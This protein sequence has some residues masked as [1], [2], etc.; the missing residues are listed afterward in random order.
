MTILISSWGSESYPIKM[1]LVEFRGGRFLDIRKHYQ[2]KPT[3]KGIMLRSGQYLRL[4]EAMVNNE[5]QIQE[6]FEGEP[7]HIVNEI[8]T[9][10]QRLRERREE[11]R[12]KLHQT[13]VD[14]SRSTPGNSLFSVEFQGSTAVVELNGRHPFLRRIDRAV[15]ASDLDGM[16][17]LLGTLL[18]ASFHAT[19][20]AA[21]G[22]PSE[23]L[24]VGE[25]HSHFLSV[26]I[27]QA[28]TE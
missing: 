27:N 2:E 28:D 12:Q 4:L 7:D 1:S 21:G 3:K 25:Q 17:R 19:A 5:D 22:S 14:H 18:Q 20:L 15:K 23:S 10:Q 16:H 24:E 13:E 26:L 8:V 6:W 11:E 9:L